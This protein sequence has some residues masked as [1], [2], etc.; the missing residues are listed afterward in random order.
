MEDYG[1]MIVNNLICE[2]LH[3]ENDMTKLYGACKNLNIKEQQQLIEWYNEEYK[4]K[5]NII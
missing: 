2:T 4:K 1:K 5:N 3:P